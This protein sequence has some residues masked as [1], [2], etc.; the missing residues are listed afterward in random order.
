MV[1][2]CDYVVIALPLT[3]TTRHLFDEEIF[4]AMKS[5][6]FLVNVG[7]GPIVKEKD[8][9]KA[10]KKGW[11]AGAGLDVFEAEPLAESSP[12]WD[13]ENVIISPHVAGFTPS[14]DERVT[15]LF[16]ENLRRYLAQEPL[17]NVVNREEG[18]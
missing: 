5:N 16:V 12:L 6:A 3:E 1:A 11:I 8:L 7:R 15:D 9:V 13:L 17:L 18:Y 4:R 2:E 10:L 14:Y